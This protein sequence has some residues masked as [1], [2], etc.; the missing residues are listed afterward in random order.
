MSKRNHTR[1]Q[2]I[3]SILYHNAQSIYDGIVLNLLQT[4]ES[5][6]KCEKPIDPELPIVAELTDSFILISGLAFSHFWI[7]L[8]SE[9]CFFQ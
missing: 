8:T 7:D 2:A 9:S 5:I 4:F 3:I 1:Q 6:V